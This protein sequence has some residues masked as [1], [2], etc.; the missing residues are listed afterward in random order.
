MRECENAGMRECENAGMREC[1]NA[2]M[3]ECGNAGMLRRNLPYA[4]ALAFYDELLFGTEGGGKNW[5]V[6]GMI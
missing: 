2:G 4:K 5:M 1:G 6:Y 3:R